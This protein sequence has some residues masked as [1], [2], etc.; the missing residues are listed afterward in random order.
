MK[1]LHYHVVACNEGLPI[2]P[3]LILFLNTSLPYAT[4]NFCI[5]TTTSGCLL[6]TKQFV[7]ATENKISFCI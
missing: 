7:H 5:W 4:I 3:T 1:I 6:S 2:S